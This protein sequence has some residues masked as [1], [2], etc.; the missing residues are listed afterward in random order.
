MKGRKLLL[1]LMVAAVLR[2]SGLAWDAWHHQHPDERFLVMVA[3]QLAFPRTFGEALDPNRTPLNPQNRGFSF[4]VYGALFPSLNFTVATLLNQAN[5]T[6]LLKSGRALAATFDCVALILLALTAGRLAG[7]QVGQ[8]VA[9]LYAFSG[10]FIQNAR[11]GTPDALGLLAV[12]LT[13]FFALRPVS[14]KTALLAGLGVGLAVATRPNLATL[15]LP[16]AIS[17]LLLPLGNKTNRPWVRRLLFLLAAGFAAFVVWK[18]IDPGFFASTLS[19]LPNPRR[20]AS[21]YE[22]ASMM[23]GEGQFPPNLQWVDRGFHFLLWNVLFWGLGP[24]LG[25]VAAWALVQA[26]KRAFLL[27]RRVLV[28]FSWL[29][30]YAFV[31][32]TR[33]VGAVR[34]FLPALPF[35]LLLVALAI[36][37]WRPHRQ[38]VLV[39]LTAPWGL[40]W[41]ALAWQPYTRV[42]ASRFLL[43][44]FP[45][46]TVLATEAWDDALPL[47]LGSQRFA[48]REI[49]VYTPDTQEKRD[50]LL[51]ILH[52]AQV[53]VLSSQRGVG[54]ICRVP[55]AY[56]LTSE[57][58]HLLFSG[59]LG[60]R[61]VHTEERRFGWGGWGLSHLGAEEALSVYDHPPV[62]IFAKEES[63]DHTL[64]TQLL[65][66]VALPG[67]VGW[68][69]RDLQARGLPPYLMK[70]PSLNPLPAGVGK[71]FWGQ[72]FCVLLWLLAV[73]W[74]GLLAAATLSRCGLDGPT[75][76]LLGRPM[77]M[78]AV[79][80]LLLWGGSLS[81]PGWQAPLPGILALVVT[82]QWRG[83]LGKLMLSVEWR[84]ARV[85]FLLSFFFFLLVRAFNPEIYWGEKPMD[86][87]IFT[88]LLRCPDLPPQD[89]WFAGY[90]LNYYFFGFLPYVFLARAAM[91]PASVAFNVATA[92][93]PALAFV[94]AAACGYALSK[95]RAG[96]WLAGTLTQLAGTAYFLFHPN[97]LAAPNFDR[98]WASSRVIAETINEYPVWTALFA[99]LHAH[100]LSTP[101]FL[102]ALAL[103]LALVRANQ[104]RSLLGLPLALVLAS[105]FMSNTW[106]MPALVVL[107]FASVSLS[108]AFSS[109]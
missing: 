23:R 61:L 49:P 52:D 32:A 21:F 36:R 29:L 40:A 105:Q 16:V 91:V 104:Q 11:F 38:W 5:Y 76:A 10:L 59:Q 99:D 47:G 9:W 70:E 22:L 39:G 77:G 67:H 66:R 96:A 68:Q 80:M 43:R 55:D 82:A 92:T 42:E 93:V 88:L 109:Y 45:T 31:Q 65:A 28:L 57:F 83:F 72:A 108:F 18:L 54:S 95:R 41:A 17:L 100:F 1:P 103:L 71:G 89:P 106:E 107:F 98:F 94:A 58:Y 74:V 8:T 4:F 78:L 30:P 46:G 62:W 37:N 56:P 3:D 13:L 2:F 26:G 24:A 15:G 7:P 84:W 35:L 20:L 73:E 27:D 90:P 53:I 64:A 25:L 6:G 101:G 97:H 87:A 75:S 48:Y 81:V 19:P 85:L 79:G 63:Y 44:T 60:F 51:N 14:L 34:H 50:A 33:F 102:S 69:T 86:S 12:S